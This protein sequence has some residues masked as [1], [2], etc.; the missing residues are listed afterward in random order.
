MALNEEISP[1]NW[2]LISKRDNNDVSRRY[3]A[4]MASQTWSNMV[5]V[6]VMVI[7]KIQCHKSLISNFQTNKRELKCVSGIM[8]M[9]FS[10]LTCCA[11]QEGVS[12]GFHGCPPQR[13]WEV[14][15]R[16]TPGSQYGRWARP[17]GWARSG[18]SPLR[19]EA[20]RK[21]PPPSQSQGQ[22]T[23]GAN[24]YILGHGGQGYQS[25]AEEQEFELEKKSVQVIVE[26]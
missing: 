3:S 10:C 15:D 12:G 24:K 20:F 14:C 23:T 16:Q 25:P 2:K 19:W 9:M 22:W 5:S 6:H 11:A 7:V 8:S 21:A 26:S 17:I 18:Q 4:D 1:L 13:R